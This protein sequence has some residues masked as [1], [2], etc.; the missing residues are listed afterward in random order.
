M[1]LKVC[2]T[3]DEKHNIHELQ[4]ERNGWKIERDESLFMVKPVIFE[5]VLHTSVELSLEIWYLV[6]NKD[7]KLTAVQYLRPNKREI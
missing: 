6:R 5:N 3:C 2:E 7:A 1:I 4:P